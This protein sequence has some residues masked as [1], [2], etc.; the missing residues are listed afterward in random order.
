MQTIEA[1]RFAAPN[2]NV[3]LIVEPGFDAGNDS[4]N[5]GEVRTR[6]SRSIRPEASSSN[7]TSQA[8]RVCCDEFDAAVISVCD[9]LSSAAE[10]P[11]LPTRSLQLVP[12]LVP[13]TAPYGTVL[14][15]YACILA[16]PPRFERGTN[17]LEGRRSI[18]LSYGRS[19]PCLSPGIR[20][21][22]VSPAV[23]GFWP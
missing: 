6:R 14:Y 4:G 19:P 16:R 10:S 18:Q 21:R 1:R 5:P 2:H 9:A 15:K 20:G 22:Q 8:S 17:G 23:A 7:R 3:R 11:A 12:A 13:A